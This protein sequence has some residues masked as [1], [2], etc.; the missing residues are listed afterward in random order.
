MRRR[1]RRRVLHSICIDRVNRSFTLGAL[2]LGCFFECV[3]RVLGALQVQ[4]GLDWVKKW[5]LAGVA[6]QSISELLSL[7]DQGDTE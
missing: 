2:L 7:H 1:W 4:L 5:T 6:I 3:C